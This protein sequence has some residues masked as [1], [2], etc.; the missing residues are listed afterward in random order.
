LND[1]TWTTDQ[2]GFGRSYVFG[3]TSGGTCQDGDAYPTNVAR[4]MCDWYDDQDDDD[5]QLTG[6]G[7]TL[8]HSL[9]AIHDDLVNTYNA[10]GAAQLKVSG[11]TICDMVAQHLTRNTNRTAHI[12]LIR[13]NGF[14][15]GL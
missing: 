2:N 14:D 7:D 8:S 11:I 10:I 3:C 15:C 13:N 5:K 12:D 9:E 4:A 6:A 1:P